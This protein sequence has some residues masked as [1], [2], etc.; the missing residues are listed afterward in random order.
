LILEKRLQYNHI[1]F[2]LAFFFLA[3]GATLFAQEDEKLLLQEIREH[4]PSAFR[5]EKACDNLY[6]KFGK[7]KTEDPL[8]S[9]YI[10]GLYIARSRHVAL[11]DK[12]SSLRTGTAMLE[13]AITDKPNN[14]ELLFLR[15]TIQIN[16]PGFLGYNDN[17]ESDKKFVID[18][19]RSA[20]PVLRQRIIRFFQG[21]DAFTTEEKAK[22]I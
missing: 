22:V 2:L 13:K 20:P 15:L 16:L 5:D 8:L 10:G 7:V 1:L 11:V 9:G 17:I 14:I 6:K 4:L 12:P 19:Y 18:N 21:N 3:P